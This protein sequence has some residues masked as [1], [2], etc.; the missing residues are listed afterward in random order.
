MD[1]SLGNR[2]EILAEVKSFP[3]QEIEELSETIRFRYHTKKLADHIT[4]GLKLT[5]LENK[6]CLPWEPFM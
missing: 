6:E 4:I 2:L 3:D 5:L 1:G